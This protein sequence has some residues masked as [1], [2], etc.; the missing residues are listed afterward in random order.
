M[1]RCTATL[2]RH[3]LADKGSIVPP[4]TPLPPAGGD[5]GGNATG[6][7]LGETSC[8]P[9]TPPARGRGFKFTRSREEEGVSRGGAENAEVSGPVAAFILHN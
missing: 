4:G 1:P 9:Q 6:D 2:L 7:G 3:W 5:G 8:P